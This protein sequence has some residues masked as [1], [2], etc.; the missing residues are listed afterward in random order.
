[1]DDIDNDNIDVEQLPLLNLSSNNS[2]CAS[3]LM[4]PVP[5]DGPRRAKVCCLFPQKNKGEDFSTER[6][7]VETVLSPLLQSLQTERQ[8]KAYLKYT[9]L[10]KKK[11]KKQTENPPL[12]YI[13]LCK[14]AVFFKPASELARMAAAR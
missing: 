5:A 10:K 3:F 2:A 13:L 14:L 11:K 8:K 12:H 7:Q 4:F 1:M 6:L 9:F